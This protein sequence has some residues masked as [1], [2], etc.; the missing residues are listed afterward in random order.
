MSNL[1]V[2]SRPLWIPE[3]S[4]VENSCRRVELVFDLSLETTRT[5]ET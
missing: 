1:S 2:I 3:L 4:V 5:D